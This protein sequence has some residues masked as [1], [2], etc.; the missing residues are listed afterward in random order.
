MSNREQSKDANR[1]RPMTPVELQ[2]HDDLRWAMEHHNEL[3]R[4]YPGESVVVWKKQ[5]IA[6]GT[7]E[8]Q[9]LQQAATAD[10]PRDQLVVVEFPTF[11][12]SPR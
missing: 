3:E 12:E 8:E 5:V 4:L 2:M 7:D 1:V 6:H 11:F 10:R 9:L